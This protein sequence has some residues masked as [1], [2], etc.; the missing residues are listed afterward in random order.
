MRVPLDERNTEAHVVC[1]VVVVDEAL[2]VA[3]EILQVTL[4]LAV[5]RESPVELERAVRATPGAPRAS[6]AQRVRAQLGFPDPR[7][8]EGLP[9][10]FQRLRREPHRLQPHGKLRGP[11]CFAHRVVLAYRG[12]LAELTAG[13]PRVT[14]R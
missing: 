7:R 12:D 11:R 5:D 4:Q 3:V 14:A 9:A 10:V 8:A 13:E 1:R 6:L 2:A